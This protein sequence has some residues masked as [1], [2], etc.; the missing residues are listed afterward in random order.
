Y[1]VP[2]GGLLTLVAGSSLGLTLALRDPLANLFSGMVVIASSKIRPGDYVR[3][4]SGEEGYVTDIRWA[5]TYIRQISNNL[6]IV[7]NSLI[8]NTI[9]INY[10]RPEPEMA[11]LLTMGVS[12][13]SNLDRVEELVIA[14]ASE[15]MEEVP[16]GVPDF[17]PMVRY[18][19]FNESSIDFM[20]VMRGKSFND[21]FLIKHEFIKRLRS[22]FQAEGISIPF[23]IRTITTAGP[24]PIQIQ[25][26]DSIRTP[27]PNGQVAGDGRQA[28]AS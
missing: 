27:T 2:V 25:E 17:T 16:G 4:S 21:Q 28:S 11:V 18:N 7:P 13:N 1:G 20:V 9:M 14:V 26:P 5:D 10:S 24:I 15:V 23:P 22:C 8:T 19:T 6:I 3:L 12:Y